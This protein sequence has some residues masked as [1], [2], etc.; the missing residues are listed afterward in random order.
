MFSETVINIRCRRPEYVLK[1][2][3]INNNIRPEVADNK[4]SYS[5]S[6][7]SLLAAEDTAELVGI[8]HIDH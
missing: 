3:K 2:Y 8:A 4:P 1:C 5:R 6:L 7:E